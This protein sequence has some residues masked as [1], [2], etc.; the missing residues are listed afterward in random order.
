MAKVRFL[1]TSDWQLGMRRHFLDEDALPRFMQARIDAIDSIGRL[2]DEKECSFVVACGDIFDSNHL[3]RRTVVRA[4]EALACVPCPVY[5]LPGNHDPLDAG[6]VYLSKA[7]MGSRPANVHVL[8][9]TTPVQVGGGVEI[10]GVPW[11]TRSPRSDLVAQACEGLGSAKD[12][13]R[14]C[15][16]HGIVDDLSP[17]RENPAL[18]SRTAMETALRDEKVHFFAVGDRHSVTRISDRIW[19][20]G[21]PEPTDYDEVDSGKCLIVEL[22]SDAI[23]VEPHSIGRW[24]FMHQTLEFSSQEDIDAARRRLEE[25]PDKNTT[26]LK[27]MLK[28][29]LGLGAKAVLD[30]MLEETGDLFAALEI[31]Q[32]HTDLVVLPDSL[33]LD[34]LGLAGFA[35]SAVEELKGKVEG[36]GAE[37][38]AARDALALLYRL[39][40]GAKS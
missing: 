7:F 34:E 19:Y 4:L 24:R 11:M 23:H 18:I 9:S 40:I 38:A 15:A 39:V 22:T 16:A 2:A 6:S 8:N 29:S 3:A 27:L 12:I 17:D 31:W 36:G 13:F 25:I 26:I 10:V 28:G 5:L 35:R 14:I 33:D 1:H 37:A 30:R 21:S 20:S 32:R